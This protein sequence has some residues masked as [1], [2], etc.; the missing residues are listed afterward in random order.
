VTGT[1][2]ALDAAD[3]GHRD[4]AGIGNAARQHVLRKQKAPLY[5][6]AFVSIATMATS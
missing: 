2:G 3:Q 6:G 4:G 1:N 5:D